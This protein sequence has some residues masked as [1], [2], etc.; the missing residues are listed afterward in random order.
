MLSKELYF[1]SEWAHVLYTN[2]REAARGFGVLDKVSFQTSDIQD[3]V[4]VSV[5]LWKQLQIPGFE[6]DISEGYVQCLEIK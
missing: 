2:F 4:F 1:R 6:S 5:S 3:W